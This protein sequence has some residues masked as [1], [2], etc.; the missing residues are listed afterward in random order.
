MTAV[1]HIITCYALASVFFLL[2]CVLF[3][4]AR[5]RKISEIT[6]DEIEANNPDAS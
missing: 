6:E 1:A 4:V 3:V 5:C 2:T